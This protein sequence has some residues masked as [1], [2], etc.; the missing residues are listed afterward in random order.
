MAAP[1]YA[2]VTSVAG[3][4]KTGA[5]NIAVPASGS[6]AANDLMVIFVYKE[7]LTAGITSTN[8][9]KPSD[10]TAGF[11]EIAASASHSLY[12]GYKR[13]TGNDTGNYS[14]NVGG[15]NSW[16]ELVC[17]KVTGAVTSGSPWDDI[18]S[19]V[20]GGNVTASPIVASTT[21]GA[22]R[23]LMFCATNVTGGAWTP[24]S[25]MTERLD[26]G[27]DITVDTLAQA[28][29]GGSGNK[30]AT[31]AG[32]GRS[33][34]WIGAIKPVASGS[35]VT[36]TINTTFAL[37]ATAVG[38]PTVKGT[39]ATTFAVTA[40]AVG[41]PTVKGAVASTFGFTATAIGSGPATVNGTINTTFSLTATAIGSPT[42]RATIAT[43]FAL[44]ATA[45][46]RPRVSAT[47]A[48]TFTLSATAVGSRKTRGTI[49]T[50]F[51]FT[52]VASNV[53]P[54]PEVDPRFPWVVRAAP[55]Y[56]ITDNP[57]SMTWVDISSRVRGAISL[58]VGRETQG[59]DSRACELRVTLESDDGLL[60][61]TLVTSDWWP[62]VDQGLPLQFWR[63]DS[64]DTPV[65][66]C[67]VA[68]DS[69]NPAWPNG[70][71]G[72]CQVT[73][74]ASGFLRWMDQGQQVAATASTTTTAAASPLAQWPLDDADGATSGASA[75]AGG[76]PMTRTSSSVRFGQ[77]LGPDGTTHYPSVAT[78]GRLAGNVPVTT[79]TDRWSV[80]LLAYA[81][82]ATTNWWT[83][84]YWTTTSTSAP[85]WRI[86]WDG[87]TSGST[88]L[89]WIDGAGTEHVVITALG[90]PLAAWHRVAAYCIQSGSDVLCSLYI[91]GVLAGSGTATGVTTGRVTTV[92][93]GDYDGPGNGMQSVGDVS[94]WAGQ[95]NAATSYD[96]QTGF[97]GEM[98]HVRW[99]R[100]LTEAGIPASTD[101]TVSVQMGPQK[102]GSLVDATRACEDTDGG[103]TYDLPDRGLCYVST[104]QMYNQE[105]A[106]TLSPR[107]DG[108][109][110]QTPFAA[111][112]DDSR[113]ATDVTITREGGGSRRV[114]VPARRAYTDSDT[115]SLYTDE[116]AAAIASWRAHH[117]AQSVLRYETI[118]WD[119][120]MVTDTA[121]EPVLLDATLA[122]R[123]GM[124][125]VL[126][127][128]PLPH[129]QDDVSLILQGWTETHDTEI[130][131]F[132]AKVGPARLF[133]I[134]T[135][136]SDDPADWDDTTA[137]IDSD[138]STIGGSGGTT[139]STSLVVESDYGWSTTAV[140]YDWDLLGEQVRV[141]SITAYSAGQ[142]TATVTRAINGVSKA[143]PVDT[144]VRLWRPPVI[145]L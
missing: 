89:R 60:V 36:G 73:V 3:G 4:F 64:T 129:P 68:A 27:G 32:S 91:D 114:S 79:V 97:D 105:P 100:L 81:S 95:V 25:G 76:Q 138:T 56:D 39:V 5:N 78:A 35:T 113:K 29:S 101:A 130:F 131:R 1:A 22:D 139:S 26:L 119:A 123:P 53:A 67:T 127:S 86:R 6:N 11:D 62:Y 65:L 141:T 75:L 108:G 31:C 46:G 107:E 93:A 44:T 92:V 140:P 137:R 13:L 143:I 34:S 80:Q 51:A 135:I 33:I 126:A 83:V 145:G 88:S 109:H 124:R 115:L 111:T 38:K 7:T 54:P 19:L 77:V 12:I 37:T 87:P 14:V 10:G 59:G 84:A 96:S 57:D 125:I 112:Y 8:F 20:S 142:Q 110:L 17:V 21:T 99:L 144:P 9:V 74:V 122:L 116:L 66:R 61:P 103:I 90:D 118:T 41:K 104:A 117:G 55:G 106:L 48:T 71:D 58:R 102:A 50:T 94:V 18:D 128:M 72:D 70:L 132:A 85:A 16:T 30:S 121:G 23:L 40:T 45:V 136:A 134:M 82:S 15:D 49:S 120:V 2:A 133:E 63:C 52:A 47:I 43:T 69:I 42:V 28:A 24:A 98:A